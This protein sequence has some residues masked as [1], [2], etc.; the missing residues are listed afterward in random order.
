MRSPCPKQVGASVVVEFNRSCE[1]LAQAVGE[2]ASLCTALRHPHPWF[3]PLDAA[4]WQ[5][6]GGTHLGLHRRQIEVILTT[7]AAKRSS[8][9]SV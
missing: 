2:A 8:R 7:L 3:G 1:T 4:R 9:P 6:L 5:V